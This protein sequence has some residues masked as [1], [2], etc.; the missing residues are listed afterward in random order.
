MYILCVGLNHNTAPVEVRESMAFEAEGLVEGLDRL[1]TLPGI[2]E[3]MLLSTCNR[4]EVIAVAGSLEAGVSEI[5]RFLAG[6]GGTTE[7]ALVD[8]LYLHEAREAARHIFRVASGLDSMILGE[9]QILG[10]IKE[11]YRSAADRRLTG[12]ILNRLL[13]RA[14][15]AAKRARTETEVAEGAVSVSYA[16]VELARK[17]FGDL[18]GQSV[19]LIG[20]GEMGELAAAHLAEAGAR[21]I[22]VTNRT[23][24]RA[25]ELAERFGGRA[26]RFEKFA[27]R[28]QQMDIAICSTAAPDI[29][30][31]ADRV[32]RVIKARR[33]RPMFFIDI[34]VPRNVDEAVNEIDNVYLYD[35]DDLR[36]VVE[37]NM[38]VRSREVEKAGRIIEE[39]V[40][41]FFSWFNTL[42]TE[43]TIQALRR[44]ADRIR[45]RELERAGS[46]FSGLTGEQRALVD[47]MTR[48]IVNKLLHDPIR[49]LKAMS[50]GTD[51]VCDIETVQEIFNL[52][53]GDEER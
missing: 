9:P 28:L 1:R 39:E 38:E 45:A 8:H 31:R 43:P 22:A 4:V 52:H 23:Y 32:S 37:A 21:E 49:H 19:L 46:G 18:S 27:D 7:D 25:V 50:R 13:P 29:L 53:E 6:R 42:D 30:I 5:R 17:I 2:A 15:K 48:S 41:A 35:I 24:E 47:T 14:F 44:K 26:V 11:A 16:A 40:G 34:A 20:A 36:S 3:G 10:Q 33:Q 51:D 12:K